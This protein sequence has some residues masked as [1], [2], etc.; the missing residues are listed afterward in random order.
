MK[1]VDFANYPVTALSHLQQQMTLRPINKLRMALIDFAERVY[2]WHMLARERY[3]LMRLSDEML[4]DIG[5]SRAD[6]E[7]EASRPFWDDKG[8]KR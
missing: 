2:H 3:E 5:V 8:I 6:A 7:G 1:S 4:K